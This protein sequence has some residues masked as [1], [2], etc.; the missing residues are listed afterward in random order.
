LESI[1]SIESI[2]EQ[3]DASKKHIA[4]LEKR[5]EIIKKIKLNNL[6]ILEA[7]SENVAL[8]KELLA[9][10]RTALQSGSEIKKDYVPITEIRSVPTE[11]CLCAVKVVAEAIVAEAVVAEAIVAEAVV[12][13]SVGGGCEQISTVSEIQSVN[14]PVHSCA[15]GGGVV[16][17]PNVKGIM[18]SDDKWV[19]VPTGETLSG[20]KG[21]GESHMN[22]V[23]MVN[24]LVTEVHENGET[25]GSPMTIKDAEKE[26]KRRANIT[27]R[28]RWYH[29]FSIQTANGKIKIF[30]QK[31]KTEKET[32]NEFKS[33]SRK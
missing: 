27:D 18:L 30:P 15:G 2:D 25:I 13:S 21:G 6:R 24:G 19:D 22:V 10:P 1:E 12:D 31:W 11:E 5:K 29:L 9:E 17:R 8:V 28:T 14:E 32:W 3:I 20:R 23:K 26:Y 33:R 7:Q 4:F 16:P